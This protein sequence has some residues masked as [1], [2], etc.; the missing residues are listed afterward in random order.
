M[1][2][3]DNNVVLYTIGATADEAPE[4]TTLFP[5]SIFGPWP[6]MSRYTLSPDRTQVLIRYDV[7][8]IFRHS[9]V[10][11]YAILT[12]DGGTATTI[13]NGDEI[14][15][16]LWSPTGNSIAFVKN[17]DV[18]YIN[19][20]NGI[21][22]RLTFDGVP[23]VI[24]NG[25]PDWVYEEEVFGTDYALWFSPDSTKMAIV[26]FDDTNVEEF[27]YH[28]YGEPGSLANQYPEDVT[29]RYPKAGTT[30]PT[31]QL[32]VIDL[33][34]FPEDPAIPVWSPINA[35]TEVGADHIIGDIVWRTNNG[36]LVSWLNRRQNLL[37]MEKCAFDT[38]ICVE[39]FTANEPAGWI[40]VNT[41]KCFDDGDRC[42]FLANLE[43]YRHVKGI[44]ASQLIDWTG[45]EYTVLSVD[46]YSVATSELYFT[47][48]TIDNVH[49]KHVYKS[50]A[51]NNMNT[52][53][54]CV[55]ISPEEE[56]CTYAS[57]S[58]SKDFS[59]YS[60]TCTGPG[61][62]YT[63]IYRTAVSLSS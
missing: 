61:P 1:T 34:T 6:T 58:F 37:R 44:E 15:V 49:H 18:Y 4:I 17:N 7:R 50:S 56:Q 28:I 46:G 42:F 40:D 57:A 31:V 43:G 9:I 41:P 21:E 62:S 30:N 22:K 2:N 51:V 10:A 39:A 54:S 24:Y 45:G 60:L 59:L 25:V 23:G 27:T 13:S 52:C 20:A 8:N 53:L 38:G 12:I 19:A 36:L 3:T 5:M 32:R 35:P 16:C 29:L 33:T 14:Q 11:K 26:S 48:N 63:K 55:A 47:A